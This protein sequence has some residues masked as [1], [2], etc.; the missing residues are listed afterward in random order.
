VWAK[1]SP[2]VEILYTSVAMDEVLGATLAQA[3]QLT[4]PRVDARFCTA[5]KISKIGLGQID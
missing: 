5:E 1:E 4:S 3:H 2:D